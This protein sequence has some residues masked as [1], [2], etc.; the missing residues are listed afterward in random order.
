MPSSRD[1]YLGSIDSRALPKDS[2]GYRLSAHKGRLSLNLDYITDIRVEF[3]LH[4]AKND[5]KTSASGQ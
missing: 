3:S 4:Y 2:R 1:D 5:L